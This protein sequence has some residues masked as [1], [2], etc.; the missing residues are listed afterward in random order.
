MLTDDQ[1]E[2]AIQKL[3]LKNAN[4]EHHDCVRIS[5]EWLAAQ[6]KLKHP[7]RLSRPLKHII[8]SWGGRYVSQSDVEI[9]AYL[10]KDIS[11]EYPNYNISALLVQPSVKRLEGIGEALTHGPSRPYNEDTY[12]EEE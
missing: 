11:G 2:K 1:I 3:A 10:H 7:R 5:Y 12:K 6:K 8:E 4:H 9:A